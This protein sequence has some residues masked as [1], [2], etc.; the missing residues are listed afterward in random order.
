MIMKC[1]GAFLLIIFWTKSFQWV[2]RNFSIFI[3][4]R[5]GKVDLAIEEA[6]PLVTQYTFELE[7]DGRR[8]TI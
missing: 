3:A 2:E 5:V 6:E 8:A 1:S 7:L 4:V